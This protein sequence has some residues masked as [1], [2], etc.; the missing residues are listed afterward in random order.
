[1]QHS[2]IIKSGATLKATPTPLPP[3]PHPTVHPSVSVNNFICTLENIFTMQIHTDSLVP[4][5]PQSGMQTLKLCRCGEPGT[6]S[7]VKSVKGREGVERP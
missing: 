1:M 7:H 3:P 2:S 4:R 6:F 5:L